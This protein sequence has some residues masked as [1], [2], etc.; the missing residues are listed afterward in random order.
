MSTTL[1]GAL[2]GGCGVVLGAVGVWRSY[3]L[4]REALVPFV[5]EGDP[6]REAIEAR[7]PVPLRPRVRLVARRVALSLAWMLVA[8]YGLYLVLR[9]GALGG[10]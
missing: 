8:F 9:G 10:W 3:A 2:L 7:R 6:T 4:A 1:L 5:H